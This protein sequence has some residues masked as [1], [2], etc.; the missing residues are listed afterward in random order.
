MKRPEI[1]LS[2]C[3]LCDVCRGVCPEV[4]RLN[5]AGYMEVVDMESYPEAEVDEAIRNC[6]SNCIVWITDGP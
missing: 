2:D 4:F 6:P 5:N 3:I 1:E